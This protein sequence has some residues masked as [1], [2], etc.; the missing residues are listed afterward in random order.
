[1]MCLQAI[2]ICVAVCACSP[3]MEATR[4][5]PVDL[6]QF[7][8]GQNRID[9]MAEIGSPAATTPDGDNSCDIYKLYTRGPEAAG[10]GALVAGEVVAD[11][12][13]LGLSEIIFTP[14]EAATRNSKH[15]VVFCYDPDRRLASIKES[16][17]H[18]DE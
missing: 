5:D 8:T 9:V 15:T 7:V 1:M 2:A 3:V 4:P 11:V 18:V 14:V 16:D 13:T 17:T 12:L 10:K 6:S